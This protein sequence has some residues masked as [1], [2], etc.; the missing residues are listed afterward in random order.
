MEEKTQIAAVFIVTLIIG[1]IAVF[2]PG[3]LEG[4]WNVSDVRRGVTVL[5]TEG[6]QVHR[7]NVALTNLT[8]RLY[9]ECF[10]RAR[11]KGTPPPRAPEEIERRA[12][13]YGER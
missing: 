2:G 9:A 11:K 13:A 1:I 10:E 6:G 3:N 7:L 12:R 5:R 8:D 4:E